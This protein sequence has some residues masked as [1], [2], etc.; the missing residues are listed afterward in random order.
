M[1]YV[2]RAKKQEGAQSAPA[3]EDVETKTQDD[4]S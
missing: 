3:Q 2:E 1:V 4:A